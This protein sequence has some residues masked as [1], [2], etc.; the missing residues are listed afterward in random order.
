MMEATMYECHTKFSILC[1]FFT[2]SFR[3]IV[4]FWLALTPF[5]QSNAILLISTFLSP[6]F[7]PALVIRDQHTWIGHY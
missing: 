2:S 7:G 1:L 6:F 5:F 3:R 4:P